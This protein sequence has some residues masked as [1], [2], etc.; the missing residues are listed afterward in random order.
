MK[1]ALKTWLR[2]WLFSSD[3][4]E[5]KAK[6]LALKSMEESVN[7]VSLA[8]EQLSGFD[9]RSIT[10]DVVRGREVLSIYHGLDEEDR[11][12]LMN[13]VHALYKNPAL[14]IIVDFL[15]RSQVIHGQMDADS[16]LGLNF[17]R[18]T[19]NGILLLQD[20]IGNI[21]GHYQA[22]NKPEEDFDETAVV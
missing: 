2:G 17:S 22:A 11:T 18:A 8:R 20:E 14:Q 21:E 10:E 5:Y 6:K 4:L 15:I 1:N 16:V 12:A 3:E 19:V 9:H 13:N 7:I